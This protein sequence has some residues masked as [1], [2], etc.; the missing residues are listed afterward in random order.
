VQ[1]EGVIVLLTGNKG[2]WSEIYVLFRL[3]SE[4]KLH[5]ADEKLN[6]IKNIYFPIVKIIR[7]EI[8]NNINEYETGEN[9]RIY[10]NGMRATEIPAVVFNKE[11][12]SLLS[13]I[14]SSKSKGA[15][16][17]KSTERFMNK[18]NCFK[19][20]APSKDKT[21]INIRILDI[22]TGYSPTVGFSIKSELGSAPTL[23]NAGKTTNFTYKIIHKHQDL[24]KETNEI[25]KASGN[26]NHIN[27]R[28]RISKIVEKKG[29]FEFYA[30]DCDTF[31]NNL[32]LIDSNMDKILS[33]TLLYYYRDGVINCRDMVKKLE[34]TNPMGYIN[35]YTYKYKYRKFL[36][37]IALGM[38]P[39]TEWDGLDEANGGY[40]IVTKEGDVLAYHI[41]NRNYFEEYLL[42][43]TKYETASTSRHKFGMIFEKDGETFIRL[44]LQIRFV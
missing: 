12:D 19:I 14:K 32:V 28:G 44:N 29:I 4:G 40:I 13:E 6:K 20:S 38:R 11:A 24:L 5:A 26:K 21:D 25:Y 31:K 39:A 16:S 18:I 41:Y 7:E 27:I 9:I 22:N 34:E 42:N 35:M 23:L 33:H 15:F 2:E 8:K 3:L 37:A 30:M 1:I 43:N 10:I 17:I 36:T